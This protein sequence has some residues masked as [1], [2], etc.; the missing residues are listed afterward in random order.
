MVMGQH[1]WQG[2]ALGQSLTPI[3]RSFLPHTP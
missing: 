1:A 2:C 3:F